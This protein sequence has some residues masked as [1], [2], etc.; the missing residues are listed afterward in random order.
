MFKRVIFS[1]LIILASC[2]GKEASDVQVTA[3]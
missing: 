1:L 2:K 3:S